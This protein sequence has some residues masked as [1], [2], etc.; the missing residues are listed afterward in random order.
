MYI[1]KYQHLSCLGAKFCASSCIM[2]CVVQVVSEFSY[3]EINSVH[4]LGQQCQGCPISR[5]CHQSPLAC[6]MNPLQKNQRHQLAGLHNFWARNFTKCGPLTKT[7][8]IPHF[9]KSEMRPEI[10]VQLCNNVTTEV[11]GCLVPELWSEMHCGRGLQLFEK[12][13]CF[14][15]LQ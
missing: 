3:H 14:M 13:Q 8:H 12:K 2:H 11:I 6:D 10:D 7:R 4:I 9:I 15:L 5:L 1:S